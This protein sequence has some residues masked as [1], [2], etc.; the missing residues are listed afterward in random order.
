MGG[1]ADGG[2]RRRPSVE[3]LLSLSTEL[4]E[5]REASRTKSVHPHGARRAAI[6]AAH[7]DIPTL[8]R[9]YP[10]SAAY[11]VALVAA[12]LGLA[13]ALPAALPTWAW[14]AVSYVV[15]ANIDH[16]L[17]VLIHD[18]THNLVFTSALGNRVVLLVANLPHVFPSAMMFRYY[19]ILH[20]V[21]L[22]K[23]ERDPDVP[24]EWEARLVGNSPARKTI[25]LA[26]FFIVQ[27]VRTACYTYRVPR[28][29][30]L[31][32]IA[33]NW[34][35]SGAVAA[36]VVAVS[37]WK[38]LAYLLLASASSVG[39]HPLGARWIQ[40]HY[41]TQPFQATYS[42]YGVANRVAFNIGYHVEHHDFPS[43][44][45]VDLPRLKVLAAEHYDGLFSYGSYSELLWDF[46]F[47]RRWSLTARLEAERSV[48]QGGGV[49]EPF[50]APVAAP[51]VGGR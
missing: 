38:A 26:L 18:A 19:H 30:E 11:T 15:G 17:W 4:A 37:G 31:G 50:P 46:I 35:T 23:S 32:W 16:A 5:S 33:A 13:V 44:P 21:E 8:F 27:A 36:A 7:P 28:R 9:T 40:E 41:P 20:H 25:W 14:L 49:Q 2:L 48:A 45:W 39:L 47:E 1:G 10:L 22:N 3:R 51:A 6:L 24:T 42:Y 34:I 43:V 29:A 12:Q